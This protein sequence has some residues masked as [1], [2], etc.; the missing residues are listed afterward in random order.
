LEEKPL[1]PAELPDKVY[2]KPVFVSELTGPSELYEGEHAQLQCHVI[3]V[4]DS[5][6]TYEWFLNGVELK[7]KSRFMSRADF[8]LV[9]LDIKSVIPEDTGLYSIKV[10]NKAGE[11][12]NTH[13]MKVLSKANIQGDSVQPSSW[14]KIQ[15]LESKPVEP[16]KFLEQKFEQP[17]VW[18]RNIESQ[19]LG[20]GESL[21]LEG[22]VEP[23]GDS[24]LT[25]QW[26]KNGIPQEQGLKYYKIDEINTKGFI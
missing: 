3:P 11:A 16:P 7:A 10:K 15:E 8:G 18:T 26:F 13:T 24:T 6:L 19:E 1:A 4:G 22:F 21:R 12:V 9:T 5:T 2:E 25:V 17:P 20:E 23:R 14:G